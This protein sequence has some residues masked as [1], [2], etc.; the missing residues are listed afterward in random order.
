MTNTQ[1]TPVPASL[2]ELFWAQEVLD[3]WLELGADIH[4]LKKDI[5]AEISELAGEIYLFTH[6]TKMLLETRLPN[7][8]KWCKALEQIN[9]IIDGPDGPIILDELWLRAKWGIFL[10]LS[11]GDHIGAHQEKVVP[12][13]KVTEREMGIIDVNELGKF[14]G[15]YW[16]VKECNDIL[17]ELY[18]DTYKDRYRAT[19]I[20]HLSV[21]QIVLDKI[22]WDIVNNA[23]RT[24]ALL[25]EAKENGREED[26]IFLQQ[27]QAIN[28]TIIDYLKELYPPYQEDLITDFLTGHKH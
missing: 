3:Y 5:T 24:D 25:I 10:D 16:G 20:Y 21:N 23:T 6:D 18:G 8:T 22:F 14:L 13:L 26:I 7:M 17:E 11:E 4:E 1:N 2:E 19:P 27:D 12:F 15:C 9:M 28:L